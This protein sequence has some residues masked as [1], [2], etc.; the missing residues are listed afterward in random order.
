MSLKDKVVL[1][2]PLI[3]DNMK[4]AMGLQCIYIHCENV[5]S[6][7]R[8]FNVYVS[9]HRKNILIYIEQ[10]VTLHSLFTSENCST[11]FGLYF[12]SLSGAHTT[13]STASGICHTVTAICR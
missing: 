7:N 4:K 8:E 10:D 13:V 11:C 6:W 3:T 5:A 9:V 1:T 12:H 2:N